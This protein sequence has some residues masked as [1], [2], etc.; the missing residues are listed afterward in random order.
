MMYNISKY[1]CS[2]C[3]L[4]IIQFSKMYSDFK[5]VLTFFFW[6]FLLNRGLV[7]FKVKAETSKVNGWLFSL[8]FFLKEEKKSMKRV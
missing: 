1:K 6:L 3:S 2:V 7:K 8:A 4:E 5:S